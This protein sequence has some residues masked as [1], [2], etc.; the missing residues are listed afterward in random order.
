MRKRARK[1]LSA[2]KKL[3][4]KFQEAKAECWT[5]WI[6]ESRDVWQCD[7]VARNSFGLQAKCADIT[8]ED[9]RV[10]TGLQEKGEA[11]AE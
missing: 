11:F 1:D 2:K 10:L 6:S 4:T 9:G 5:R 8:S 3:Q 7:R